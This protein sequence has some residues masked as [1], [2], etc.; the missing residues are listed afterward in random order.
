MKYLFLIVFLTGC[1]PIWDVSTPE[2]KFRKGQEVKYKVS[3]FYS[4]VCSGKGTVSSLLT[5]WDGCQYEIIP[6]EFSCHG[7]I[8]VKEEDLE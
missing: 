3:K 7:S 1:K 4:L 8:I 6:S 2:P 5:C